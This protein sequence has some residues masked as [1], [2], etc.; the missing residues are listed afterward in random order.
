MAAGEMEFR[1]SPIAI[2]QGASYRFVLG[3]HQV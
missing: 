3:A 1:V 2:G